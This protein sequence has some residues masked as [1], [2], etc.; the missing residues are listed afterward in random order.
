MGINE[1]D[2]LMPIEQYWRGLVGDFYEPTP[3]PACRLQTVKTKQQSQITFSL[4]EKLY[5]Q[6]KKFLQQENVSLNTLL[7]TTWGLLLARYTHCDDIVFGTHRRLF[8]KTKQTSL[9]LFHNTLPLRLK[10]NAELTATACLQQV[11][12]QNEK[13]YEFIATPLT[14][15]QHWSALAADAPLFFTAIDIQATETRTKQHFKATEQYPLLL[16]ISYDQESL[17]GCLTYHSK[18]FDRRLLKQMLRHYQNLLTSIFQQPLQPVV[19]LSFL[20]ETEQQ[21]LLSTW[22]QTTITNSTQQT[23]HTLF[24]TQA[25]AT[26]DNIAVIFGDQKLTYRELNEK[27]NQLAHYL[28]KQ[29][30]K[31]ESLVALCIDRS[32]EMLIGMLG[33]LKAGG[34]YVPIDPHYPRARVQHM[35]DDSNVTIIVS[36]CSLCA[37]HL[38]H[39]QD[40]EKSRQLVYLDSQWATI[41]Q[42]SKHNPTHCTTPNNLMY[43]IYTSGSTGNPKGVLIEHHSM[44]NFLHSMQTQF[45][46]TEKDV[47][48][49]ITSISFD[50]SGLEFYLPLI[51]GA[52]CVV[53]NREATIDV[54]QLK[55]ILHQ[56]AISILQATP[57]MWQMLLDTGWQNENSIKI[58][59]GGEALSHKLTARLLQFCPHF[60]NL[61][62]PTEVTIWATIISINA[63][64]PRLSSAPIG[65]P[66]ANTQIYILDQY[67][68]LTAP[69][70]QGE[71]YIG[72]EGLA[73]GYLNQAAQTAIKFITNTRGKGRLYKTGDIGYWLPDGN[74]AYL[75]RIDN[76]IKIRGFRIEPTEIEARLQQYSGIKQATVVVKEITPCDK[77]L[78]AYIATQ[79]NSLLMKTTELR[80]FLKQQLPDYMIP[81]DFVFLTQL[82]LTP[83]GKVDKNNL[84]LPSADMRPVTSNYVAPQNSIQHHLVTF[85]AH[86]LNKSSYQIGIYDDFF[87]LGGSSLLAN[88]IVAEIH[89]QF[90]VE[91]PVRSLHEAATIANLS[92]CISHELMVAANSPRVLPE[93]QLENYVN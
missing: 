84:P 35:I 67:Q 34:A 25:A 50:I 15:I 44:V 70:V 8:Y 28:R 7:E 85:W 72:G 47:L 6:I 78:V 21:Q 91:I 3:L 11:H 53:A 68:Q 80:F 23:V 49:A 64:S 32:L 39:M 2:D 60:W 75:N 29:G 56:Q 30:V 83:N 63:I 17:H 61:Y 42:E 36:Q 18:Q 12:E 57:N 93:S 10:I 92:A 27:A 14:K 13:L 51:T 58:L 9:E 76:Q 46:L 65:K 41:A 82:P 71:I 45:Q 74:I 16:E 1:E 4:S 66:I 22:N 73:R 24:E 19:T 26:P 38:S 90:G 77:R 40:L 33:I 87:D 79:E 52:S 43:V 20:H 31:P 89:A 55:K 62:G 81:N 69:G 37:A 48:L 54:Q 5:I 88:K 86:A 59:C